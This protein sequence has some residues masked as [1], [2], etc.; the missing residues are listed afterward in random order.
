PRL[1]TGMKCEL[2]SA[3]RLAD[4]GQRCSAFATGSAPVNAQRVDG[5]SITEIYLPVR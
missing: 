4:S 5:K 2:A 3:T 1:Q